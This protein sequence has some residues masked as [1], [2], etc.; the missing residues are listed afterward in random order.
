MRLLFYGIQLL[1]GF[2]NTDDNVQGR[3]PDISTAAGFE[4]VTVTREV[5]TV[6]GTIALIGHG[7]Q[8]RENARAPAQ[9]SSRRAA[10]SQLACAST[11]ARRAWCAGRRGRA[12]S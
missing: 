4:D 6:F 5:D 11:G 7:G 3:L 9:A 1:D 8:D 2:S 12:M 10:A